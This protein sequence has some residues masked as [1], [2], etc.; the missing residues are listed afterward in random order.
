MRVNYQTNAT[1]RF[2]VLADDQIEQIIYAALE[3]L[4]DTGTR[5]YDDEALRLLRAAGCVIKD[6]CYTPTPNAPSPR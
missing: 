6:S 4:Q 3:I 2:R 5:V 1:P